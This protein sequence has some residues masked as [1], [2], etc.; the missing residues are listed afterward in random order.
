MNNHNTKTPLNN[1]VIFIQL[2]STKV[3][4]EGQPGEIKFGYNDEGFIDKVRI[5]GPIIPGGY[6]FYDYDFN[7]HNRPKYHN[8]PKYNNAHKHVYTIINGITVNR[9]TEELTEYEYITYIKPYLNN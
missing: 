5:F 4:F 2:N 8:F 3:D 1:G 7:D 9:T 6:V